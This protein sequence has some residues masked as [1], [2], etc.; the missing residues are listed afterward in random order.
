[1]IVMGPLPGNGYSA[2]PQICTLS[3]RWLAM[4]VCP[5]SDI[6]AFRQ[7]ATVIIIIIIINISNIYPRRDVFSPFMILIRRGLSNGKRLT[8]FR[9]VLDWNLGR[10]FGYHG[11]FFLFF[12][13]P[14][15]EILSLYLDW[16]RILSFRPFQ[17]YHSSVILS[18]D[19][20]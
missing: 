1:M 8:C 3:K 20:I 17:L 16:Q 4:D 14:F 6:P 10:N 19:A 2:L 5:A 13:Q 7:H 9:E 15:Q 11:R 12:T 18:L